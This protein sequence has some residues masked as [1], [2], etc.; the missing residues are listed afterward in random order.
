MP[1]PPAYPVRVATHRAYSGKVIAIDVDTMETPAGRRFDL[2][3]IRHAGAAAVIPM[4]SPAS[5][6]DPVILLIRQFRQAAGGEIWEVPAGVLQQGEDPAACAH[7]E[8]KEETGMTAARMQHLTT[9]LTTPGFTDERIHLFLAADLTAGE[10]EREADEFIET[11]PLQL[12]RAL[13]LVKDGT[14][15]DGKTAIALLYLAGFTLGW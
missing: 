5:S 11:E 9:I 3:I 7:R 13:Q 10:P 12:S 1:K 4:L 2:E 15:Q 6:E 14:I 8:L